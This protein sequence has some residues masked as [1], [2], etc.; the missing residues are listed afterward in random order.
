MCVT[1][2][3]HALFCPTRQLGVSPTLCDGCIDGRGGPLLGC[4]RPTQPLHLLLH[5]C[6]NA[7]TRK[8]K[9]CNKYKGECVRYHVH[10][11]H[12]SP[13]LLVLLQNFLLVILS[14]TLFIRLTTLHCSVPFQ[15]VL[16]R[17]PLSLCQ[18]LSQPRYFPFA[19]AEKSKKV[20]RAGFEPA[21]YGFPYTSTVHRS[22]N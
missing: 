8:K 5:G 15:S 1:T 20:H 18:A 12:F 17:A 7:P 14:V 9:R 2:D 10:M 4:R 22:T 21:T 3:K 6:N 11:H 13:E 19:L 16:L